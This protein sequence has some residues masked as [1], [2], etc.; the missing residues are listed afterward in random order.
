MYFLPHN[1]VSLLHIN[2][3]PPAVSTYYRNSTKQI[4]N[5]DKKILTLLYENRNS[6]FRANKTSRN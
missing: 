3:T 1:C 2:D 4:T 6:E 5:I